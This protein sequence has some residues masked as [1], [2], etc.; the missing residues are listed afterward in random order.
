[1]AAYTEGLKR[2]V[3]G[4]EEIHAFEMEVVIL[5]HCVPLYTGTN[6]ARFTRLN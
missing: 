6:D 2:G 4:G 1:M 5:W 3:G